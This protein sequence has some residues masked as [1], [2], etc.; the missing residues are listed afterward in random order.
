ML[1]VTLH[2]GVDR[3]AIVQTLRGFGP[4]IERMVVKRVIGVECGV[5]N[6][7]Q[8]AAIP[9][10]KGVEDGNKMATGAAQTHTISKGWTKRDTSSSYFALR[11]LG[12]P[13]FGLSHDL[14]Y[15]SHEY[16]LNRTIDGSGVVIGVV[17]SGID[18]VSELSGRIRTEVYN[19]YPSD[20][21]QQHGTNVATI[22][23]GASFGIAPGAEVVSARGLNEDNA[24][25]ISILINGMDA[26]GNQHDTQPEKFVCNCS[27]EADTSSFSSVVLDLADSGCPVICAAGNGGVDLGSNNIQPAEAAYAF[28][29]GG[30]DIDGARSNGSNFGSPV[31]LYGGYGPYLTATIGGGWVFS[32]GTSFASPEVAGIAALMLEQRSKLTSLGEVVSFYSDL[33]AEGVNDVRGQPTY[34]RAQYDITGDYTLTRTPI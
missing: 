10:V 23:A 6:I 30:L 32:S 14:L 18:A 28:A 1:E 31:D 11:A 17:D 22:A 9:G 33:R 13:V 21:P 4:V 26:I 29:V 20:G 2:E 16:T 12:V 19:G 25:A 3:R 34:R 27:F 15:A 24:G 8:I 5:E 7:P